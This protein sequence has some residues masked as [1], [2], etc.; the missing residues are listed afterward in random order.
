MIAEKSET[1]ICIPAKQIACFIFDELG[2][3]FL[4]GYCPLFVNLDMKLQLAVSCLLLR[5]E[6]ALVLISEYHFTV[7]ICQ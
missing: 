1:P 4:R 3:K 2:A 7:N 6:T 5:A